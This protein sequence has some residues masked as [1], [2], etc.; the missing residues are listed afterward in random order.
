MP[1]DIVVACCRDEEDIVESFIDF[2][3]DAGFDSICLVDNGSTDNTTDII[4]AHPAAAHIVLWEDHRIGYDVH[5]KEYYD[6]FLHLATRWVFFID[7]DELILFENGAKSFFAGL[8]D[9]INCLQLRVKDMYHDIENKTSFSH[10]LLSTYREVSFHTDA[11]KEVCKAVEVD[12]ISTGKHRIEFSGKRAVCPPDVYI[13][14]YYFRS[15]EQVRK[16]LLNRFETDQ[17]FT[18]AQVEMYTP[19]SKEIWQEWLAE[20]RTMIEEGYHRKFI[21]EQPDYEF[22]DAIKQWYLAR[23]G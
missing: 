17:S 21:E 4:R 12:W 14:H 22:D 20:T 2:Y 5:L 8:D 15:P 7:V 3:L 11:V 13:R 18:E 23:Y 6:R 9:D 1:T 10:P 16:K 19:F